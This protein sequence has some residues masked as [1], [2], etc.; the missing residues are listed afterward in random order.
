MLKRLSVLS[1]ELLLLGAQPAWADAGAPVRDGGAQVEGADAEGLPDGTDVAPGA[2]EAE[3]VVITGTRTPEQSQRATVK[4]DVVTRAEA[5][6]RG[7]TNV[8]EALATQP[9]V[10]VN[11]GAYGYLGNVSAIQIQGF[12]LNRV[13]VLEDGEPVIGDVGGAI[14]LASLSLTDIARI[15]LVTG[16]TSALYGSSA[17][18]GVVN[19]LRAPPATEG[20][21]G[22]L[23]TDYRSFRGAVLQGTGAY[24]KGGSW[25]ALELGF[26]RQDGIAGEAALPDLQIPKNARSSVGLRAGTGLGGRLEVELRGRWLHQKLDGLESTE[27]PGL[28]RFLVDLPETTDRFA[29][30]GFGTLRFGNGSNVRLSVSGQDARSTSANVPRGSPLQQT[31]RSTQSMESVEATATFADGARTWVAGVRLEGENLSQDLEQTQKVGGELVTATQ[32]EVNPRWRGSGAVYGQLQWRLGALT[33]LPGVRAESHG[34]YGSVVAPRLALALRAMDPLTLRASVGRGFRTP[35]AEELGF[36]FD[37][38]IYGYKVVGNPDLTPERSWGVNGDVT[39]RPDDRWSLRAGAFMN[40]VDDLID[41]DLASG[42]TSGTVVTYRY[43]NIEKVRTFGAQTS[44]AYR[45]GAR[46][47]AELAYDYLWTRDELNQQP[48]S[49]RPSH[50]LTAS[51]RASL[52]WSLEAY[53]RAHVVGGAF[54]D[55]T[56]RS[57][58]YQ[59]VDLRIARALWPRSQGYLGVLN[60]FDVHQVAGQVGD[61]R[62]PLGRVL[63]AGVRAELPWEEN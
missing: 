27:Y 17:I 28:G 54:V 26:T 1:F 11:P 16:P 58:G 30:Q 22:R 44:V 36:D 15:E 38:S 9:G 43:A 42:Q 25:G 63:Y 33:L 19:I 47:H 8:A 56:T 12:D 2:E 62:P 35:S 40:W 32:P 59:T 20:P 18:G 57:P 55:P 49:G 21:S 10:Q 3:T 39:W 51:L 4:T 34:A 50:T 6:R 24:R 61:L 60:L 5:E 46:L 37:H 7:A 23:R 41:V 48:L 29:L 53:G 13:L 52:P 31:Q 14:D 45:L